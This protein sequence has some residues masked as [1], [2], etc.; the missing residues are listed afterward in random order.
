MKK[1]IL[2]LL[3]TITVLSAQ[4][5]IGATYKGPKKITILDGSISLGLLDG[6]SATLVDKNGPLIISSDHGD[7][8]IILQTDIRANIQT[9]ELLHNSI[10]FYDLI[11]DANDQ[12]RP[13]SSHIYH[14]TYSLQHSKIYTDADLYLVR[15]SHYRAVILYGFFTPQTRVLAQDTLLHISQTVTFTHLPPTKSRLDAMLR[16]NH[17]V[18][19]ERMGSYS[20]KR[21]LWLCSDDTM[22][23]HST[24]SSLN[25]G[26]R[27]QVSQ[28]GKWSL[29]DTTLYLHID[30]NAQKHNI[31]TNQH[32]IFIDEEQTF[33]LSNS[34]CR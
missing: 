32:T 11:L 34:Y 17:F 10:E 9:Q 3:A 2:L 23:I 15:G 28:T 12:I 1:T 4:L 6:W 5:E 30:D 25:S 27:V 31:T 18:Y 16:G 13:I 7:A 26:T 29:E 19:Y 24:R 22:M 14:R 21:E 8:E 20:E 33:K